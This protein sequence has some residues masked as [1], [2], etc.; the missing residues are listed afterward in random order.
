MLA[1]RCGRHDPPPILPMPACLVEVSW[2][3]FVRPWACPKWLLRGLG[4]G[5][6]GGGLWL[7]CAKGGR[8]GARGL[9]VCVGNNSNP[10][11]KSGKMVSCLLLWGLGLLNGVCVSIACLQLLSLGLEN[12]VHNRLNEV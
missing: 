6:G 4:G 3:F 8:G 11:F 10:S 12:G 5:G 1:P 7:V 9:H 2:A